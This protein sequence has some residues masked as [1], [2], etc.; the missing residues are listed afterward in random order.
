MHTFYLVWPEANLL[1]C[2][3]REMTSILTTVLSHLFWKMHSVFLVHL[4]SYF[5]ILG[6]CL[7]LM[8]NIKANYCAKQLFYRLCFCIFDIS[9]AEWQIKT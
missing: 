3:Q 8:F 7:I 1:A 2:I 4:L 5:S 9:G 6:S